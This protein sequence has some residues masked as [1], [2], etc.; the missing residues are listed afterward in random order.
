MRYSVLTFS[1]H[2]DDGE[3]FLYYYDWHRHHDFEFLPPQKPYRAVFM[4]NIHTHTS[5]KIII[6]LRELSHHSLYLSL[7]LAPFP[8]NFALRIFSRK[9]TSRALIGVLEYIE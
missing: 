9:N 5:C 4:T 3:K 7:S 2:P 8:P 1:K 6:L